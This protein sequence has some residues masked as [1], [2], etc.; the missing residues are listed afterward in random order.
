MSAALDKWSRYTE[1][2]KRQCSIAEYHLRCL[3]EKLG[4]P[5]S[6]QKAP[7]IPVQAHFEG[8]IISVMAAVDKVAQATNSALG[9]RLSQG[10]LVGGAMA[11]LGSELLSVKN[12]FE[13]PVGR[14]L[15]CIRVRVIHYSYVKTPHPVVT[16]WHVESAD[17][18][19]SGSRELLA[20][21]RADVEY[22]TAL[23][24]II[25]TIEA[26]LRKSEE[27]QRGRS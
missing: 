8:V 10:K 24:T 22:G 19:Y 25:P 15:R 12:W 4:V 9:L 27:G 16:Q 3:Q 13:K 7:P 2:A 20:Y 14:D 18:D 6:S 26:H 23:S 5:G 11:K 1:A 17:T 21:S